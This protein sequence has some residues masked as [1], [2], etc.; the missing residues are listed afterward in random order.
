MKSLVRIANAGGYW[1]DDP[2]ALYR[3]VSGG[4]VDYVTSDFLAEITMV[5]L[6]RQ[7]AR[8]PKAGFAYDFIQQLKPALQI[9]AER[10]VTVI[11]NAGG[12]NPHG[13]AEAVATLCREAGVRL[14]VGVV[15]GDNLLDRIEGLEARGV[16]LDHMDGARSYDEIRGK[17]VAANVYLGAKPVVEALRRGARI[18]VTGRTTDA[19]LILAPLVHEFDWQWDDWNRI[20]AGVVAG[21]ILE[22]GAQA[23]GGN[24][25]DWESLPSMLDMGYPI[26][27]AEPDG[28]FVVTKHP[29]T[30]GAVT[31]ATVTE[32]LLYEIGDPQAYLTP[33]VTVDFT[34]VE[35]QPAGPDRVRVA[36]VRGTPPP[37][38][39]KAS[40]VY[41]DGFKAVGTSLMS[42]P[43]VVAKGRRLADML[44]HRLGDYLERRVDCV[45]YRGCWGG[46]APDVEPNEAV[47]RVGVRDHDRRKIERFANHFLAFGLQAPPGFGIFAGRPDVQEALG[48]WPALV[49][50]E[51][52]SAEVDVLDGERREHCEVPM[53]LPGAGGSAARRAPARSPAATTP[54]GSTRRL[55][56]SAIAYARSGDKGDHA[57]I[58]VAARTDAAYAVLREVLTAARVKEYF[59][60]LVR[61]DVIRYELPNLRAFNFMLHN[62]LG[63]GGTLSLRVDHQGKTL[64]QG[65]LQMEIDVPETV[66]RG[67]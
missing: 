36:D 65:L 29:G 27:E 1:G 13:C 42:G 15:S 31:C 22:C 30:G 64:A 9:I 43:N 25:T 59:A 40:V 7:R 20:A 34:S 10:G 56:L 51:L 24:F 62:A 46:A 41:S 16:R 48:F 58:G 21:H 49:P 50:R 63:G 47:F 3:Q 18:V 57:N 2:E 66:G 23:T 33:D 53:A 11:V 12:I 4:P 6:H 5:I 38:T 45:G 19:A 32:Q 52:V 37:A 44:F 39:L 67:Q 8:N 28:A 26:V 60:D 14:P 55:R 61:G 35:L 54:A 17:V